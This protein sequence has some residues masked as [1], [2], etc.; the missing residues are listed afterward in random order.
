VEGLDAEPDAALGSIGLDGGDAV[1]DHLAGGG[2]VAIGG[3]P[4]D[5]DEEIGAEGYGL[6]DGVEIVV[7]SNGALGC[8]GGGEH[9]AA[10]EAGDAES[11]VADEL[12]C[13]RGV[14]LDFVTPWADPGDVGAGAGVYGF[15]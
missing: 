15:G 1:D 5:E 8:G 14:G 6:I 13:L 3:G 7:D 9:S 4:V 11:G 2:D 12:A 10:A